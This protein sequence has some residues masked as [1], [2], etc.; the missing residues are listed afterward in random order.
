MVTVRAYPSPVGADDAGRG[1]RHTAGHAKTP[2]APARA[3]QRLALARA[4]LTRPGVIVLDEFT[5]HLDPGLDAAVRDAVRRWAEGI[6]V[7]EIT[8]RLRWVERADRVVVIDAGLVVAD[9]EPA[10]LL[11]VD[12]PLR[13]LAARDAAGDSMR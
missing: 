1:A 9:G 3:R 8:H 5:S 11:A 7:V 10:E 12:G 2:R 4:L 13:R 6:T